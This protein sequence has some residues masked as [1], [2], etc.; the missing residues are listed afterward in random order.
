M[1]GPPCALAVAVCIA[2]LAGCA[3]QASLQTTQTR[4]DEAIAVGDW[5]QAVEILTE[6]EALEPDLIELVERLISD[7]IVLPVATEN[8]L[9]E[10]LERRERTELLKRVLMQSTV[11]IPAG[12]VTIGTPSG[13]PDERPVRDVW[14]SGYRID[15]HEVTNLEFEAFASAVESWPPHWDGHL[16]PASIARHPVLGVSWKDLPMG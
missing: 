10:W 15:R 12:W 3:G 8:D 14:V 5:D 4:A 16:A 9:A 2:C 11:E 13:S 1:S 7:R 6:A